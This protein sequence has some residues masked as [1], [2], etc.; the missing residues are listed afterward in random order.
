MSL[1]RQL[2][3]AVVEFQEEDIQHLVRQSLASGMS[4]HE[5]VSQA[6]LPA[7]E[8]V[9]RL[10]TR[11]EYFLPELVMC[12]DTTKKAMDILDP[13]LSQES[14]Q[15]QGKIVIGTVAGDFHDIGK[16]MV[17][18]ML[19]GAGYEVF[20]LGIDVATARFVEAVQEVKPDLL[21]MSA[22]LLTT[23]EAMRDVISSLSQTNLRH[24]VKVIVGGC[25]VDQEFADTIGADGYGED[26]AAAINLARCLTTR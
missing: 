19:K 14:R 6:L 8:E 12:G 20:D 11:G 18:S 7:M 2:Q 10:Y 5:I 1:Q 15:R 4:A 13:L 22:L 26:A 9:G 17:I 21:G 23:R 3:A 25:A 16:N 24:Q